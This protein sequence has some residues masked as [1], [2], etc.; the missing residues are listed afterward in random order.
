MSG[1]GLDGQYFFSVLERYKPDSQG[2]KR[3]FSILKNENMWFTKNSKE[4][5]KVGAFF[6]G[7]DNLITLRQR[8]LLLKKTE[9]DKK[10]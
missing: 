5:L 6:N 7:L 9:G 4:Q 2:Y 10:C 1:D 3:H 8:M